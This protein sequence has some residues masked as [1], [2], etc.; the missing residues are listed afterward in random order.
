MDNV[1]NFII[2]NFIV[3]DFIILDFYNIFFIIIYYI[4]YK[5]M[6]DIKKDYKILKKFTIGH[7]ES[8]PYLVK[9]K[10]IIKNM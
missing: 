2:L 1:L 4:A 10:K 6:F 7:T 9:S 8:I 5:S 3:L